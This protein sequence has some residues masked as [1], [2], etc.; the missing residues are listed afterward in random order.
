MN[1]GT[2]S[3]TL[4]VRAGSPEAPAGRGSFRRMGLPAT[5]CGTVR[6]AIACTLAAPGAP[7]NDDAVAR[8]ALLSGG[9]GLTPP[10]RAI[11]AWAAAGGPA[12]PVDLDVEHGAQENACTRA[13]RGLLRGWA[14]EPR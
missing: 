8:S 4:P 12:V 6:S 9:G 13:R 14:S 5:S 3:C 11:C 7:R 10:W 2:A 1:S